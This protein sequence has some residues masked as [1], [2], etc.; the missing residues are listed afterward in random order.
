MMLSIP[1]L[2]LHVTERCNLACK[3]CY[4]RE[5]APQEDMSFE[6]GCQAISFYLHALATG[7]PEVN[8]SFFGGEPLLKFP[9]VQQLV[10]H[11]SNECRRR[12][13]RVQFSMTTNGALIRADTQ[14]FLTANGFSTLI[15]W[16][17][18]AAS[19][20]LFRVLPNQRGSSEMMARALPHILRLPETGVRITWTALTL[21]WLASSLRHFVDLGFNWLGFAPLDSMTF[22]EDIL[23]EYRKQIRAIVALWSEHLAHRRFLV[24]NPLLKM[25]RRVMDPSAPLHFH[26]HACDPLVNR[27]SV[28]TDG[29]L[30]PCHRFLA[31]RSWRIGSVWDGPLDTEMTETLVRFNR[32]GLDGCVSMLD[33]KPSSA[34]PVHSPDLVSMMEVTLEGAELL[35]ERGVEV[36]SSWPAEDVP[37]QARPVMRLY[38]QWLAARAEAKE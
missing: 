27:I 4:A 29:S 20:D 25:T 7:L 33:P 11:A 18:P 2:Q 26:M 5:Q 24:I 13:K 8:I 32:E 14:R 21:P 37:P 31:Q 38:R 6:T 35:L 22:T 34:R 1:R 10:S 30:F 17:G 36:M 9:L 16:D 15:S 19:Q 12:G 28:G 3:Y 23:K